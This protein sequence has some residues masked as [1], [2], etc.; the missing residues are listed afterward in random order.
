MSASIAEFSGP[1]FGLRTSK[2][3]GEGALQSAGLRRY[4]NIGL[5][6]YILNNKCQS[7]PD[8]RLFL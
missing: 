5:G 6:R 2:E 8:R 4:V 1:S 3:L 7:R